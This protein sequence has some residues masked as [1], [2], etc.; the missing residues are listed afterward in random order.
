MK[1]IAITLAAIVAIV[2]AIPV[3]ASA[4]ITTVDRNA[5]SQDGIEAL[6]PGDYLL[7][8]EDEWLS[9][10]GT[11]TWNYDYAASDGKS[12]RVGYTSSTKKPVTVVIYYYPD[13]NDP[14]NYEEVFRVDANSSNNYRF[15]KYIDSKN[16]R[17]GYHEVIV[18]ND[19]S[20][21]DIKYTLR[22][23]GI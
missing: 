5:I 9:S 20:K 15:T 3:G 2:G 23:K 1:K 19:G 6:A 10:S 12:V 21:E 13:K 11:D 16:L 4:Q 7:E 17:H 18:T 8:V 14:D 22:V